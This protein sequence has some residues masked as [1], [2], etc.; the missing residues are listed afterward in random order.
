MSSRTID[1]T[2]VQA[3]LHA[4]MDRAFARAWY[5]G[6]GFTDREL[7]QPLIAVVTSWNDF[8]PEAVHLRSLADAVRAGI[9]SAHATPVSF[10]V[11]HYSDAI[12]MV[13]EAM[14]LSL[15]SRELVADCLEA[16]AVGHRFDGLV[17]VPGGDKVV[18]GMLL[19]AARAGLPSA[20]LYA[21]VTEPAL[22]EGTEISWGTVVEG[23][24]EVES[25]R[26]SLERLR[27]YEEGVL[28]GP[29]GGAAAYTGNT[30]GMAVEALG[31]SLPGTSTLTAGSN[32]Q[33]RAAKETGWAVA[34]LV[35]ARRSIEHSLTPASL[36]RALRVI[37]AAGGSLNAVLH[38][39]ALATETGLPLTLA[40]VDAI[41]RVTP[42]L[43]NLRP[44]GPHSLVDLHAAGGVPAL[45]SALG[46]EMGSDESVAD[47]ESP[48]FAPLWPREG[49]IHSSA[50]PVA[51]SGSVGVLRG[52]LAP[53]GSLV[54]LSAVPEELLVHSGPARVFDEE[55][56]AI[57]AIRSGAIRSGDVVVVRFQGPR[58]GPGFP[59]ML[60]VTAAVQGTGLGDS[61][62][63][64]TDGRFSGASR[65]AVIG[66]V[67]PEAAAE[68]PLARVR[69]GDRIEIN[70]PARQLDLR[71]GE[72]EL[73]SRPPARAPARSRT[74]VLDRYADLVGPASEGAILS[75]NSRKG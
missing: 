33:L 70:M 1:P 51:P 11:I 20:F 23:V 16:M 47:S 63:V 60:G 10:D 48:S 34:Q 39:L 30:M 54:K 5:K 57:S 38:L 69:E 27:V 15:P 19:G 9:R 28:P 45:L 53:E 66:Y 64:V 74:R 71:V 65:G 21:G 55:A 4:G 58:G 12:T 50:D 7:A 35:A 26:L 32:P 40:K 22:I 44:S 42:Q 14:R 52:S 36:R 61:V 13:S 3:P 67:G 29:G 6:A 56:K 46:E 73:S 24:S 37:A 8:T 31:L 68:G 59:E 18:P 41:S 49:I 75:P 2:Q 43:V 72:D 17:L 62:V 25:G